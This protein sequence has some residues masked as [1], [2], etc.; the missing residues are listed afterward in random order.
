MAGIFG[1][2]PYIPGLSDFRVAN[3]DAMRGQEHRLNQRI[4]ILREQEAMRQMQEANERRGI[5]NDAAANLP[6]AERPMFRLDPGGYMTRRDNQQF[7]REEAQSA[8]E[9]RR[10]ELEMR[11]QDRRLSEQ[12]R[13]ASR[14]ELFQLQQQ[15]KADL[16]RLGAQMRPPRQEPAPQIVQTESGPMQVGRDGRAVPIMGPDGRPV[17]PKPAAPKP[18]TEFQGKS[19]LYGTRAQSS[20]DT[21]QDLEETIS[22]TGLA[23]KQ[24]AQN[25]PVVGGALGMIGNRMLSNDQQRVEQAQRDFVNAVLRQESGAVISDQEFENAKRQYFP[26]PGDSK[27]VIAQKRKNREMAISGFERMSGEEGGAAIRDVRGEGERRRKER[28][29]PAVGTVA[30]GYRFTGGDPSD[31]ANW[32]KVKP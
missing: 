23:A 30:D 6:E 5:L 2:Q 10:Q 1:G 4:G 7:R 8:R 31:P 16:L 13:E 25:V 12:E 24:A 20:H 9:A 32:E 17:K 22:T 29:A 14:R 19:A 28:R 15:G 27:D 21:L 18:M 3:A 26:Q 11:L